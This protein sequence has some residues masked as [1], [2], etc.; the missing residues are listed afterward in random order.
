MT[1]DKDAIKIGELFRSAREGMRSLGI[2]PPVT[3]ARRICPELSPSRNAGSRYRTTPDACHWCREPFV[4]GQMR[5]PIVDAVEHSGGW[6]IT[7]VCMACFKAGHDCSVTLRDSITRLERVNTKCAGCG[8]PIQ[9]VI[10]ARKGHWDCCSNRCYQRQYRKR[11]RGIQSVVPWKS[12]DPAVMHVIS[13]SKLPDVMR[14]IVRTAAANGITGN[15]AASGL[16]NVYRTALPTPSPARMLIFLPAPSRPLL[17][18]QRLLGA[19][20]PLQL[21]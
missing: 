2:E 21:T 19:E 10:G 8:E 1:A 5:Y 4:P 12:G 20:R 15:G 13:L 17:Y 3:D 18:Q 11:R 14:A 6:G 9:T 7:S 16:D